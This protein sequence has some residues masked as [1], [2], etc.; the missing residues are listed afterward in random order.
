MIPDLLASETTPNIEYAGA[1]VEP[2]VDVAGNNLSNAASYI[3]A[4]DVLPTNFI[5]WPVLPSVTPSE[6]PFPLTPP[7]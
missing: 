7:V 5:P 3:P 6:Y 2:F 4:D 1:A